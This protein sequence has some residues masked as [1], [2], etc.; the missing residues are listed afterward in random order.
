MSLDTRVRR[1]LSVQVFLMTGTAPELRVLLLQRNAR[2]ELALPDFWQGVSGALE[3][4][5]SFEQSAIR[6]V[7]EETGLVVTDVVATGF[8]S[9][10]TCRSSGR[11]VLKRA[12]AADT[13]ACR[14]LAAVE[15]PQ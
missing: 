7:L 3:A 13:L 9:A 6:E 12:M 4:G 2:P 10:I 11:R 15:S 8:E 5:E 1:P 14:L